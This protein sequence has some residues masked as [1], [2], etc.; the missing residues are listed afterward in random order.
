MRR[1]RGCRRYLSYANRQSGA[2]DIDPEKERGKVLVILRR[3]LV[4]VYSM[5]ERSL[6]I[7]LTQDIGE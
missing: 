7:D 1:G 5:R 3:H 2:L 6:S 4:V